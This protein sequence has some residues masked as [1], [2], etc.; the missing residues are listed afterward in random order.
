M[1]KKRKG[2]RGNEGEEMKKRKGRR[3][4]EEE[5]KEREK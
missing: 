4:K 1:E 3:G 2:R 5:G